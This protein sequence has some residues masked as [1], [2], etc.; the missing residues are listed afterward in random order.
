M[1][2]LV[3]AVLALAF[4]LPITAQAQETPPPE[5]QRLDTYVGEW[6]W[7]GGTEVGEWLGDFFVQSIEVATYASGNTV[8]T[9][10]V[11][12]YDAEEEVYTLHSYG[13]DGSIQAGKGWVHG[14]TWTWLFDEPA[15]RRARQTL[16]EESPTVAI[17]KWEVSIE[18]GDWEELGSETRATKV[19]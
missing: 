16:V 4:I 3:F 6:T 17:F 18:G 1:R 14:N 8:T 5:L 19:R 12:G 10:Y 2:R 11:Y 13:S 9:R 7:E 15:G